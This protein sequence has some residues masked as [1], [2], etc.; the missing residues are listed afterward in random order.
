MGAAEVAWALES[1]AQGIDQLVLVRIAWRINGEGKAWPALTT[2]AK[3]AGVSLATVKRSL[4]RLETAGFVT[5]ERH[6][7][8]TTHYRIGSQRATNARARALAAHPELSDR[9][10]VSH[11][12]EEQ[13]TREERDLHTT[14][15]STS[16]ARVANAVPK[17]SLSPIDV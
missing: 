4:A 17:R 11:K 14:E 1:G 6:G 16:P 5:R 15:V 9:L 10:T 2:I 7:T 12:L 8:R 3:D 13:G